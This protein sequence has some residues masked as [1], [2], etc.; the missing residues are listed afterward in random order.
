MGTTHAKYFLYPK[1]TTLPGQIVDDPIV[2]TVPLS[3]VGS[4]HKGQA[5]YSVT[6]FTATKLG[7]NETTVTTPEGGELTSPD[8]PN[9]MDAATPFSYVLGTKLTR[10]SGRTGGSGSTG[11]TGGTGTK[12]ATTGLG[13]EVPAGAPGLAA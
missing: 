7:P 12:L 4:P 9:L 10:G 11:G 5:L 2:W 8:I 1:D 13:A 3:D 6:G